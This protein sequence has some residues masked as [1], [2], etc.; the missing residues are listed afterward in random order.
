MFWRNDNSARKVCNQ[1]CMRIKEESEAK[2]RYNT[3]LQGM[4]IVENG[5]DAELNDGRVHGV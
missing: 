1:M 4:L 3:Y 2:N 5:R